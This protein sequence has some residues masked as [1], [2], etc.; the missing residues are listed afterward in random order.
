MRWYETK[1]L[2]ILKSHDAMGMEDSAE[3]RKCFIDLDE[4]EAFM[5]DEDNE[6][7]A[8]TQVK[9]KSGESFSIQ[10]PIYEFVHVIKN[11]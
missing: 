9:F 6:N 5:D 3:Y 1:C 4:V 7:E 11:T 10:L 2:T 8:C